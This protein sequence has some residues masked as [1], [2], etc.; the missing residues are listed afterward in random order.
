MLIVTS[1]TVVCLDTGIWI[2]FLLEEEPPELG[3][4]A[5]EL[6]RRTLTGDRLVAPAFAW[7]E[8]GSVLRKKVRRGLLDTE[9]AEELWNEFGQMPIA[10]IDTPAL[11][12]LAWQIAGRFGLPTLYDASF[13]ACT[14]LAM[15][16]E[17]TDREFWTADQQL[18]RALG[19]ARPPYVYQ[20]KVRP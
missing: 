1:K 8:V 14:E 2:K 17:G 19:A 15:A 11:R 18:L 9:R 7:A 20:L 3:E 12:Q 5:V 16:P 10:Y 4:A 13:L 6:V